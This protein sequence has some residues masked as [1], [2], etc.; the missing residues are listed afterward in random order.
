MLRGDLPDPEPVTN[1]TVFSPVSADRASWL[2]VVF[3]TTASHG[4]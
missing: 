1:S 4:P 2:S 3:S